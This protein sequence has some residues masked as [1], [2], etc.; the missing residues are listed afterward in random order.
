[1]KRIAVVGSGGAGKSTFAKQLARRLEL[2]IYHLDAFYWKPGWIETPKQE[3]ETIHAGL[4]ARDA[5]VID[6]NYGGTME[7]RFAVA[8]AIVFLNY[9][10]SICLFRAVSR[11]LRYRGG[12]RPEMREGCPEKLDWEFV[13]WILNFPEAIT[14]GVLLGIERHGKG[15]AVAVFEMPS[16]AQKFLNGAID[17][18]RTVSVVH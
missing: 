10:R 9:P 4:V 7:S 8:D 15:K 14:P 17:F 6:G 16:Q 11:W 13:Q 3:W 2:P 12:D 5:W 18:P 1:M